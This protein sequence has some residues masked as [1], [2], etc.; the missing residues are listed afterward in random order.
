VKTGQVIGQC[1]PRHR[2]KEFVGF[3][4]KGKEG[5]IKAAFNYYVRFVY[6]GQK[7]LGE[8]DVD[9]LA[10]LQDFYLAKG[11]IQRKSPVE[12]LYTSAFVR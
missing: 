8:I 1:L 12:E 3:L 10:K 7:V 2:A 6:P 11:L 9:R 4:N 5:A